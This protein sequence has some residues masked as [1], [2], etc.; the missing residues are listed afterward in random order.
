MS[1]E[2]LKLS[3]HKPLRKH[4]DHEAWWYEE[5]TGISFCTRGDQDDHTTIHF[6]PWQVIR[7]ALKRLEKKGKKNRGEGQ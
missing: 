5:K 6:I 1:E 3:P 4:G 7:Q 2:H